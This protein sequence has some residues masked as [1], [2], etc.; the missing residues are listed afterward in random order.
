MKLVKRLIF[1]YLP[2]Q[3]EGGPEVRVGIFLT[4]LLHGGLEG[5]GHVARFD[6]TLVEDLHEFGGGAVVDIPEGE[7]QGGRA[8]AKEAALEAKQFVASSDEVHSGGTAAERHVT[9]REAHLIEIVEVKVAI[10]EADSGEHGV[11]LAVGTVSGD[12]EQGALRALG[13]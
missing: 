6:V 12:M 7:Q 3:N 1:S 8:G 9:S 5:A 11:V 4:K 10:A 13:F 2:D